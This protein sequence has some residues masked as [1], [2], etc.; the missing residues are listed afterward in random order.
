MKRKEE[1]IRRA[2]AGFLAHPEGVIWFGWTRVDDASNP[3]WRRTSGAASKA[4]R[5]DGL[6]TRIGGSCP[7]TVKADAHAYRHRV[8]ILCA[9]IR[10][11][12]LVTAVSLCV[13]LL[14]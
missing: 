7:R 8:A 1:A 4:K 3:V 12:W 2:D 5:G 11:H 14:L 9:E 6:V 10:G 13:L